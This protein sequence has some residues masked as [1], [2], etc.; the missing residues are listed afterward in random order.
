MKN[1]PFSVGRFFLGSVLAS[2]LEF[3]NLDVFVGDGVFV[4]L[5]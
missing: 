2:L 3:A 1:G 5:E 4:V